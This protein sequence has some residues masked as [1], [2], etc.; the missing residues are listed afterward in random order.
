VKPL[1]DLR[2]HG[3]ENFPKDGAALLLGNHVSYIDWMV[4]SIASPRRV[5]F[6][7]ERKF[8]E[9]WYL[10]PIFR[11]F[12]VIPISSRASKEAF[13]AVREKLSHGKIVCIF[14]EGALTRN[15]HLGKFQRG[16]ELITKDI[17]VPII[18]FYIRGLWGSR[19]SHAHEKLKYNVSL[20]ERDIGVSFGKPLPANP[21]AAELKRA[22]FELQIESWSKDVNPQ[23]VFCQLL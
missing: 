7:I 14:P 2:I 21:T 10:K 17:D 12:G 13:K 20:R 1:V 8:Y 15:G 5:S 18:P 9:K 11:F 6:V 19:F 3:V 23:K 16:F 22:I 4:L